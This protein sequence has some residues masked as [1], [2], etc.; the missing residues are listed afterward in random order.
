M[1]FCLYAFISTQ[2]ISYRSAIWYSSVIKPSLPRLS[3]AKFSLYTLPWVY[4]LRVYQ[5]LTCPLTGTISTRS[6]SRQ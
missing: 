2:G 1:L 6:I 4:S 5:T 3:R